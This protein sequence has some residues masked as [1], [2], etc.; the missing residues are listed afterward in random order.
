MLKFQFYTGIQTKRDWIVFLCI[1]LALLAY[2][3][4]KY[5]VYA[6]L[7]STEIKYECGNQT[8]YLQFDE[9]YGKSAWLI[10]INAAVTFSLFIPCAMKIYGEI[11]DIYVDIP[12][13]KL[14]R[15]MKYK[16]VRSVF[17]DLMKVEYYELCDAVELYSKDNNIKK[18]DPA[19]LFPHELDVLIIQYLPKIFKRGKSVRVELIYDHS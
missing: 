10:I 6:L 8:Y 3:F 7:V 5:V 16:M 19:Q 1:A 4:V 11:S 14:I 15:R 9:K 12:L 2:S 13:K 18:T 17:V